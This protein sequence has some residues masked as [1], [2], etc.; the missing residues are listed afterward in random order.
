M[1]TVNVEFLHSLALP[2]ARPKQGK[3]S[4]GSVKSFQH[5]ICT[6]FNVTIVDIS[7][8]DNLISNQS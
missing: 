2:W 8:N 4:R 3:L 5:F 1:M 6:E 7:L